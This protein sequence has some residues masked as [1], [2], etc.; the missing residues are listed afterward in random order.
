M[1]MYEKNGIKTEPLSSESFGEKDRQ[2]IIDFLNKQPDAVVLA[3]REKLS[4]LV[5]MQK[6]VVD[7]LHSSDVPF[8]IKRLNKLTDKRGEFKGELNLNNAKGARTKNNDVYLREVF[9]DNDNKYSAEELAGKYYDLKEEYINAKALLKDL[10]SKFKNLKSGSLPGFTKD[11]VVSG[12]AALSAGGVAAKN[13]GSK[14]QEKYGTETY[15]REPEPVKVQ[16]DNTEVLA[17][18]IANAETRGE[19]D[20]YKTAKWSDRRL[21]PASPLGKDLGKYQITSARLREKSKE[22]LGRVVTDEEF[23]A[24]PELQDKFILAQ[25]KWQKSHGLSDDEI[26]ATHR[27]GWGNMKPEQLKKAVATSSDYLEQARAGK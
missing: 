21:G 13:I 27:R 11:N 7:H 16:P 23:L 14:L 19:A 12:L 26:L 18:Q 8:I 17:S 2:K 15:Q 24:S 20:P 4:N 6:Q 10:K 9:N 3:E 5:E 22:F 25:I 1:E